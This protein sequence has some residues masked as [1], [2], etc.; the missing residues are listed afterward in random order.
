MP[1]NDLPPIYEAFER[2][3][4][5]Y[6]NSTDSAVIVAI[7]HM[8]NGCFIGEEALAK[9]CRMSKSNLKK[10]LGRL[11]NDG[12][13]IKE[14]KF[15]HKG[16]RQCYHLDV[17]GLKAYSERVSVEIPTESVSVTTAPMDSIKARKGIPVGANGYPVGHP[18]KEYKQYK[19][20]KDERF[21]FITK[22]LPE[23]V[24]ALIKYGKNLSD[25][26][27]NL[28]L[29]GISLEA[30]KDALERVDFSNSYKVG[31][32]FMS[33]LKGLSTSLKPTV[34]TEYP[35]YEPFTCNLCEDLKRCA[36]GNDLEQFQQG[37]RC[38]LATEGEH[39]VTLD[40]LER[41]R[42]A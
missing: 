12:I 38:F 21:S 35:S 30:I 17:D 23:N 3:P 19:N 9:R 26:L 42:R 5:G 22:D 28:E 6:I 29:L 14:Q 4:S 1:F 15:A 2:L 37:A 25:E 18:Y 16:V 13:V 36:N 7:A 33:A 27:D 41:S 40:R 10:I 11:V 39:R 20:D 31:G 8:P 32:L 34:K 24:K